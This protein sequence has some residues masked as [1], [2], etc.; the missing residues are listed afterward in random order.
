[1][2]TRFRFRVLSAFGAIVT[3]LLLV[4]PSLGA[5]QGGTITGRVTDASTGQPLAAVQ[6]FIS[7]LDLGGLTQQNGRYLLQNVPAGTHTLAVSRIGYRTVEAQV[8]VGGGQTVEQNF[9]VAEEALQLDEIIVTGTAGGTQ[10]RA[11]GNAVTTIDAAAITAQVPITTMQQMLSARTPGL[12]FTRAAGGVGVGSAIN[13]RGFSSILIG[14]QPLIYVDGIRVDNSFSQGPE[15][16]NSLFSVRDAGGMGSS[17]LDDINPEDIESIE[18]IKGP[19]AATLYGTE[20]SAGV[21]QIITKKERR[22]RP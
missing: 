21:I 10:R 11:I 17:A 3:A 9:S 1:M 12:N 15:N 4:V 6:V 7:A 20:A 16:F 19:A 5:Q 13:I 2:Q 18:I 22:R 8:T 14:N